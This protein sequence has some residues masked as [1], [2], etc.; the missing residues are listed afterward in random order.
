MKSKKIN[1]NEELRHS[2][3]TSSNLQTKRSSTNISVIN[4]NNPTINL[5][6]QQPQ[7][8]QRHVDPSI[9]EQF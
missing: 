1:I 2:S 5:Q 9:N 4:Y 6:I 3:K 7:Q 8:Q